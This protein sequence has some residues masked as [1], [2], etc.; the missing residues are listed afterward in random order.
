MHFRCLD[1][2]YVR[3]FRINAGVYM[4]C[5]NCRAEWAKRPWVLPGVRSVRVFYGLQRSAG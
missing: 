2:G 3:E 4:V 1:C 5:P